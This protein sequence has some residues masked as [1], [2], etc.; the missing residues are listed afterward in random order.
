MDAATEYGLEDHPFFADW[1][2]EEI[3]I[4]RNSIVEFSVPAGNVFFDVGDDP[5]GCFLIEKGE[6]ALFAEIGDLLQ[7]IDRRGPGDSFGEVSMMSHEPH[8]MRAVAMTDTRVAEIPEIGESACLFAA[9]RCPITSILRPMIRHLGHTAILSAQK[10]REKEKL[11]LVGRMVNDIVHDFKSPFQTITLGT[12]AIGSIT[13]D[14]QVARLCS[15]ITNQVNR[16]LAMAGELAEFS[17]G[18]DGMAFEKVKLPGLLKDLHEVC[19][20]CYERKSLEIHEDVPDIEA[21]I[22]H[23]G[24]VRV[25]QNLMM[26]ASEAMPK[27]GRIDLAAKEANGLLVITFADNGPGIPEAIRETFWQPFVT[28]GKKGGVGLG[29]AI[30]RSIVEGHGGHIDFVTETGKG[31]TFTIR[32]PLSHSLPQR[33]SASM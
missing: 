10:A 25:L 7:E 21:E 11:A 2:R 29:S 28:A 24:M 23:A 1:T 18:G 15:S 5:E 20:A 22:S 31:T 27:G 4:I 16:M 19:A 13:K 17:R 3:A 6:V 14:P 9:R 12:E 33:H 8:R 32:L 30:V 26:N